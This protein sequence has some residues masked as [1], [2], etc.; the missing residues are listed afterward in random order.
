MKEL[1]AALPHVDQWDKFRSSALMEAADKGHVEFV[2]LFLE[3]NAD[4][5]LRD[6]GNRTAL[7]WAAMRGHT[8]V[9][10][11][12]LSTIGRPGGVTWL[13]LWTKSKKGFTPKD[14]AS[15][16]KHVEIAIRTTLFYDCFPSVYQRCLALF[17]PS[18]ADCR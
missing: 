18:F 11:L 12:L 1:I 13:S 14:L 17:W 5:E 4:V 16:A 15:R 2:K 3:A 10:E 6:T 9:V 7:H 8:E